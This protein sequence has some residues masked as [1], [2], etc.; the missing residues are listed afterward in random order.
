MK[1]RRARVYFQDKPAGVLLETDTGYQ[2]RYD[3]SFLADPAAQA[4]SVNLPLRAQ[5][6]ESK[7]L[8]PFFEGLLREGWL[9]EMAVDALA[10]DPSDKF[11]LLLHSGDD[12]IGAVSVKPEEAP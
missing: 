1:A 5:P 11:G 2:F 4:L 12:A 9:L 10:M 6:F 7:E 8:F 3:P